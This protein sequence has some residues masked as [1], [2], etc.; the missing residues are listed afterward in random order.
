MK[1]TQQK[2]SAGRKVLEKPLGENEFT[3][4]PEA[5]KRNKTKEDEEAKLTEEDRI[6]LGFPNLS[7][8]EGDDD[9]LRQR[10]HPVDFAGD[11][12]DIPGT[13]LDDEQENIGEE[14]EENNAYSLGGERHED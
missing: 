14:D 8:D 9:L 10:S 13:E 5:K 6:A 3:D 7:D 2:Q 1:K 12:L 11:D 4:I